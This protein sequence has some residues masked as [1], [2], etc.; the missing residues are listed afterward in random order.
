MYILYTHAH[1]HVFAIYM[2]P[3][4]TNPTHLLLFF[5][6]F[7]NRPFVLF[8]SFQTDLL[9]IASSVSDRSRLCHDH[10]TISFTSIVASHLTN[11]VAAL[12]T[13]TFQYNNTVSQYGKISKRPLKSHIQH[14]IAGLTVQECLHWQPLNT[15]ID[16]HLVI[17]TEQFPELL[18]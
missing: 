15:S 3:G 14:I 9:T 1:T 6:F 2:A 11:Q 13:Q 18:T 7:L 10:K 8:K 17:S 5:L 16:S 12:G 4:V